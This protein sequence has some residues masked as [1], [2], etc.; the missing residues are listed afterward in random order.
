MILIKNVTLYS[1]DKTG[2]RDILTGGHTILSVSE[3]IN[4]DDLP[5][6]EIFDGSGLNAVPGLIDN[7]VHI[8]GAGGEGGP[9]TRT[10][11][12]KLSE[13]YSA[14]V[15]TVIGCLGTD[16]LTR[17]VESVLMKA[18]ALRAEG[19]SA[20][21]LTGAYQVPAPSITGDI[22][23]DIAVIDEV[24]GAGEIA[25]SDHRSSCPTTDELI[26]LT[27]L[28][29]VGGMLGGKAGIVNIH[30]GDAK[31]PFGPIHEAV[32]KSELRYTQFLPTHC[33]RN[34]YI[35]EDSKEYGKKGYV[36]ITTSSYP[37]FPDEEV[38]PSKALKLLLGAGVPIEHI[39]FSS[40][41]CGSLPGFDD[42][43][44]LVKLET[45][46]PS[47]NLRELA[48]AVLDEKIPLETAVKVLTSSPATILKLKS[49]GFIAENMDADILFLDERMS[50]VHL[51]SMGK[52]VVRDRVVVRKGVYEK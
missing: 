27:A 51:L 5:G 36:D 20:W 21:I 45:G 26:R 47:S 16:G 40:D 39:T 28:A 19:A 29:R 33:N 10:A 23:R 4:A 1:P 37:Y 41:S 11:E 50:M 7:H 25:L 22:G 8:A 43:G 48:D 13:M 32:A 14:G 3:G 9:S 34:D 2:K 30:L 42:Q 44:R 6:I 46:L 18:K 31:D 35:F 38:K 49:K 12:L 15:T 17:S 24:I 52:W